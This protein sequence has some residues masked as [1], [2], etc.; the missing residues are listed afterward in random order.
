MLT[1]KGIRRDSENSWLKR[2]K[3]LIECYSRTIKDYSRDITAK[4]TLKMIIIKKFLHF[5]NKTLVSKIILYCSYSSIM[6]FVGYLMT[7]VN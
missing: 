3:E 4:K 5:K 2:K 6:I 1:T 7:L